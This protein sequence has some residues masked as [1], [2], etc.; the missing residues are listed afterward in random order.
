MQLVCYDNFELENVTGCVFKY[1]L[2][3]GL[4]YKKGLCLPPD[5]GPVTRPIIR[6]ESGG[7]L[8]S[9]GLLIGKPCIAHEQPKI[10]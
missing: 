8:G 2:F 4:K 6:P 9:Q 1:F 5:R 7:K 3:L 10:R